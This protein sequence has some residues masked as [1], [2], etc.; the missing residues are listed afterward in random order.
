VRVG[1]YVKR[2]TWWEETNHSNH[3]D[4][5]IILELH[6]R[7][8]ENYTQ[9]EIEAEPIRTITVMQA[10]GKIKRW[11]AIHTEVVSETG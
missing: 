4:Y 9:A 3:P 6:L 7:G 11:Y 8:A 5:G 1:D 10:C 2:S